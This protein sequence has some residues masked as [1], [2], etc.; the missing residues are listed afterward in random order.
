[1]PAFIVSKPVVVKS[2]DPE[3]VF[4]P[5]TPSVMPPLAVIGLDKVIAPADV[6]NEMLP[7][8]RETEDEV[9]KPPVAFTVN[10]DG[11]PAIVPSDKDV[12]P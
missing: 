2:P 11:V 7:E 3:I 9:V 1:M 8:P 5:L 12:A 4:V 10:D 6:V